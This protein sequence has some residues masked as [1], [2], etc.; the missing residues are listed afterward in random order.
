[1]KERKISD[2]HCYVC[3]NEGSWDICDPVVCHGVG[4]VI[5]GCGH[6]GMESSIAENKIKNLKEDEK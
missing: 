4:D 5:L 1:M 3:G 6:T 2:Y